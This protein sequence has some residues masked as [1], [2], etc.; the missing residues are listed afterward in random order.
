MIFELVLLAS[1]DSSCLKDAE[2]QY[3]EQSSKEH[4]ERALSHSIGTSY[5]KVNVI[6]QQESIN[7]LCNFFFQVEYFFLKILIGG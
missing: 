5:I 4:G 2:G 6:V 7:L 1:Y 3:L